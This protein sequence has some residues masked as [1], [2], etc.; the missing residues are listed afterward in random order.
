V[1]LNHD[2]A[3]VVVWTRVTDGWLRRSY[4]AGDVAEFEAVGCKLDVSELYRDPL[5]AT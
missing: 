5:S 3:E 1:H 4:G 2:A